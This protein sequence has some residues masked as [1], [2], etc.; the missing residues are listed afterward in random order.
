MSR[1]SVLI[2]VVVFYA[3]I[4]AI[5][6]FISNYSIFVPPRSTYEDDTNIKKIVTTD[7]KTISALYFVSPK[8]KY[9]IIYSH[10]NAEDLGTIYSH[11]ES[12]HELGFN[13]LAY[14]YEGYGTSE[15]KPSEK[16]T[17]RDIDASYNYLIKVHS[18]KPKNIILYGRSVGSG[19]TVDLAS[20]K[21][22][23]GVILESAFVSAYRVVTFVPLFPFDKFKNLH[24][25]N[26]MNAPLL[27][28]HGNKDT[29]VPFWHG[30]KLYNEYNGTKQSYWV[31]GANH[32]DITYIAG[33]T[34][35]ER[36]KKF[37]N[38]REDS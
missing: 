21:L 19:P 22:V 28:I 37:I 10:G 13:V 27:V 16:A 26:K 2:Q 18:V 17:Y 38:A 35:W 34:Y 12:L 32:N 33:P 11:V 8:A 4:A 36:I 7:G 29:V 1:Y 3:I 23:G 25:I 24:K 6:H 20:R 14:D 15:G 9:T 5:V 31:I 30:E